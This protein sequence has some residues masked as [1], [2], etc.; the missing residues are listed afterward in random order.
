IEEQ[1]R[2]VAGWTDRLRARLPELGQA[3]AGLAEADSIEARARF[4]DSAAAVRPRGVRAGPLRL[5][6]VRHPPPGRK[7]RERG[8]GA[9]PITVELAVDDRVLVLSGPNA[10]GKTVALKTIGLA[11]VLAQAGIPVCAASAELPLF[12]QVRADIGDHQSIEA[13]LS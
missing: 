2:I 9:V 1:E 13:D 12:A 5:W 6:Q 7:P 8:G 10:G 3:L 4:A 11:C